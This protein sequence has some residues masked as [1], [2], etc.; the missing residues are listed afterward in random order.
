MG[1]GTNVDEET[2]EVL[3]DLVSLLVVTEAGTLKK[4]PVSQ[5]PQKGR[6]TAGVVT[7]EL[8]DQDRV[9]LTTLIKED[10]YLLLN[11]VGT[12]GEKGEHALPLKANSIITFPRV[13]RGTQLVNGRVLGLVKLI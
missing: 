6:A 2:G 13:K 3:Q 5:Y 9:L 8:L 11:W 1:Y 10:D 7:T 4:V 12:N